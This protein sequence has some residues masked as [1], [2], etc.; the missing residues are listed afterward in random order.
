MK[1]PVSLRH[2]NDRLTA[3]N[4]ACTVE[5]ASL[6]F[7]GSH[8]DHLTLSSCLLRSERYECSMFFGEQTG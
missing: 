3:R 7:T 4:L 2:D 6:I 1:L 8:R 5:Y